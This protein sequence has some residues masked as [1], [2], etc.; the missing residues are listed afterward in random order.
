LEKWKTPKLLTKVD[1]SI[2]ST[3]TAKHALDVGNGIGSVAGC[4]GANEQEEAKESS[5]NDHK[6]ALSGVSGT[7]FSPGTVSLAGVFLDLVA[8]ELVV[9]ETNEGNRVTEELE[10]GDRSVPDDHG[11]DN[12]KDIL[13]DTAKGH[14][15]RRSLSDL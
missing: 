13:K 1:L 10:G 9:D 7:V 5:T 12:K 3:G 15:Q 11:G 14:D 4:H 2:A 8:T 6:A